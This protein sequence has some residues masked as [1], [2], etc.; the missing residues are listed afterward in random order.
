MVCDKFWGRR[1]YAAYSCTSLISMALC[2]LLHAAVFYC[3]IC[4]SETKNVAVNLR[5]NEAAKQQSTA[6]SR[7]CE[8]ITLYPGMLRPY[9]SSCPNW[10][11]GVYVMTESPGVWGC[12]ATFPTWVLSSLTSLSCSD[13][14]GHNLGLPGVDF[15]TFWSQTPSPMSQLPQLLLVFGHQDKVVSIENF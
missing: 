1:I 11:S 13:S 14:W 3:T 6:H 12:C 7:L 2:T 4:F 10:R 9:T 8:D 5:G 15:Q